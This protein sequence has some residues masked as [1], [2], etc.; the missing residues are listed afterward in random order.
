[1]PQTAAIVILR[2]EARDGQSRD[3]LLRHLRGE[4]DTLVLVIAGKA[5]SAALPDQTL[6]LADRVVELPHPARPGR[7][8]CYKAGMAALGDLTARYLSVALTGDHVLGPVR[9]RD[10]WLRSIMDRGDALW[11]PYWHDP[12]R[13][14]GTAAD[15]PDARLPH[16]DFMVLGAPLLRAPGF[17]GMWSGLSSSSDYRD[18]V[19][20]CIRPL[21]GFLAR[22]GLEPAFPL[23]ADALD[24]ARPELFELH[25]IVAAGATVLPRAAFGMDP[26]L[27]DLN[28]TR[29]RAVLDEL[30]VTDPAIYRIVVAHA[31]EHLPGRDFAMIA[32]QYEVLP[33][34]AAQ[35]G[36]TDWSFGRVGVFIHAFYARMM[37]EFWRLIEALPCPVTLYISAATEADRRAIEG[38]LDERGVAAEDR[39]VRVVT[40][41][42][43]RDMAALFITFRDVVLDDRHEVA[44][45][46]HSKRTPQVPS[47]VAEGFKSHLFE[48]LVGTRGY[49]SNLLDM[50]EA[51]PDIGLVIPPVVHIGFGTLGHSWFNNRAPLQALAQ[52]MGLDVPVD[53]HTPVTAYGTMFWFRTAALRPMFEREW[54]WEDYNPEPHHVDGGLAH[55]QERLIGLCVQNAGFRTMSVLTTRQA[56]RNYAKLEYKYQLVSAYLGSGNIAL[57]RAQLERFGRSPAMVLYRVM[58][59][60]YGRVISRLPW[61]RPALRPVARLVQRVFGMRMAP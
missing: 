55:V 28:A 4:V 30:R 34:I 39:D 6:M 20:R 29:L 60:G 17:D 31:L 46:L 38:F 21:A 24:T 13:E 59:A 23:A 58:R 45:R 14:H 36:K 3:Y 54:Q 18:E 10:G 9:A 35:P 26:V 5:R 53:A 22:S 47:P 25:R 37:P 27:H 2:E 51:E 7:F 1:M 33:D 48:N 44:L 16:S 50:I 11:S 19:E 41:N 42:R 15:A 8:A 49:A 56:A 57:Q 61:T 52:E 32:D 43:G 12:A 40:M